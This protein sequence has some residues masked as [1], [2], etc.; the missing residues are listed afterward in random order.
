MNGWALIAA[1]LLLAGLDWGDFV[2]DWWIASL[3]LILLG[4]WAAGMFR[5]ETWVANETDSAV[6]AEI[7]RQ[8]DARE[9]AASKSEGSR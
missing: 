8:I 9:A 5:L 1:G 6:Y 2:F 7:D 4:A 3:L